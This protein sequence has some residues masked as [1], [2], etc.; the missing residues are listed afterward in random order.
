MECQVDMQMEDDMETG[1]LRA[2]VGQRLVR[3]EGS[4]KN[5]NFCSEFRKFHVNQKLITSSY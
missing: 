2:L 4:E 3:V 1:G 5:Q